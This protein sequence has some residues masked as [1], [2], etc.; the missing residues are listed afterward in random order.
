MRYRLRTLLIVL[1]LGPALL[2]YVYARW[3][4]YQECQDL[5]RRVGT[6]L[7]LSER[8]IQKHSRRHW[9]ETVS[10]LWP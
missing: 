4:Q 1:A 9:R 3:N 10:R 6:G 8:D 7:G 5:I 2:G